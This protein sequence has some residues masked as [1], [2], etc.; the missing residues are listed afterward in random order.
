MQLHAR[1][2]CSL[3][4]TT[5]WGPRTP[6]QLLSDVHAT[7]AD[8]EQ[9]FISHILA[10]FAASDGIV[11]ENLAVR[12]MQGELLLHQ[13]LSSSQVLLLCCL[14]A[15]PSAQHRLHSSRT[16][17]AHFDGCAGLMPACFACIVACISKSRWHRPSA[18]P[19]LL[20]TSSCP[21]HAP[22]TASR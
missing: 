22:S 14:T 11:L 17:R 6:L 10:F 16:G 8:E 15:A 13:T 1:G 20:Q 3:G 18:D 19:L 2:S 21:R 7:L 12:F 9:H 4:A 5:W